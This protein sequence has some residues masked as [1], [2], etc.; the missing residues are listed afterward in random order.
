MTATKNQPGVVALTGATGFVG[1]HVVRELLARGYTV[2]GLVRDAGKSRR[3]FGQDAGKV[4]LITG[5]ACD[6]KALARLVG[7]ADG[8]PPAGACIHLIGIIRESRGETGQAPQTFER[9][10]VGA[11]RAIVDACRAAGVKR[12]IHM[13]ALGA[14]SDGRAEYQRTKWE[15]EQYVRRS[16]GDGTDLDWTIFRPALIHGAG[17]EFVEMAAKWCAGEAPPYFFL[18]Y[19]ARKTLDERVPAGA[20]DWVPPRVQPVAVE[21]VA[22]AF[23]EAIR[24]PE[25]IGEIY[26]LVGPDVL[27]WPE[28]LEMFRD[29]IPGSRPELRPFFVPGEHAAV[30]AT[31]A[32]T[33]GLGSLL[34]F[35]RGQALMGQ[36]DSVADATKAR[37][38]LGL[39]P[40]PFLAA[41]KSYAGSV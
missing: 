3:V 37:V 24:R 28:M 1:R 16:F 8:A 11:T 7:G 31:V 18:P 35:D 17:G 40:R 36:E 27:T 38:Q 5:D 25:A 26:N 19:F 4:E 33:L 41:L 21:D 14:R 13:S 39:T 9:M 12:Y 10:H 15:A 34:P 20:V 2:R 32:G 23:A 29:N 22:S 30:I 6:P